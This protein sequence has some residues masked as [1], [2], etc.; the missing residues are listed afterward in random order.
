MKSDQDT[1]LFLAIDQGGHATRSTV[2]DTDGQ[3]V[4]SA[5]AAIETLLPAPGRVEHDPEQLMDSV[6]GSLSGVMG[7]LGDRAGDVRAAGL[8]TQRASVVC[9][10]RISGAALSPVISWQDRRAAEWLGRLESRAGMIHRRTGL[11]LSPHYGAGKLRWCLD[12]LP[13]VGRALAEE[14]LAWG[15]LASFILFRLTGRQSLLVDP[16]NAGRTQLW[17]AA[18]LDW[19]DELLDVFGLPAAPL[20]RCVPNSHAFGDIA[21][22]PGAIPVTVVTGDQSAALYCLGQPA[23]DTVYVNLGTG[24]FLQRVSDVRPE[25]NAG[26]LGSVVWQDDRQA[27]FVTEGTVNGVGSAIEAVARDLELEM[28]AVFRQAPDWLERRQ[29]PPLFLNGIAGLGSP[30][31]VADFES[32]FI[33]EGDAAMRVVAVLESIVF[34]LVENLACLRE[35]GPLERVVI[36]G[37]LAVLDGLCQRLADLAGLR[38]ERP[39]DFEATSR[40][41]AW[42]VAGDPPGWAGI[43]PERHWLSRPDP[44]LASRYRQWRHSLAA[45]LA[46]QDADGTGR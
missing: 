39:P 4:A 2:Y 37:G 26:L 32:R 16:V 9:W 29:A 40:G 23:C 25:T 36:S 13:A 44:A 5:A 11:V 22:L 31:W 19:S 27:L 10:D 42:R 14:R 7:R 24:G 43:G 1:R 3:I 18:T 8:A 21:L 41:L 46:G 15:P 35:T 34:L 33:G 17:D 28:A 20:P 12:H 6:T 38:V 45:A 30:F